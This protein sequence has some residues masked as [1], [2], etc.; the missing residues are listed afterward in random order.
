METC[1]EIRSPTL[2]IEWGTTPGKRLSTLYQKMLSQKIQSKAVIP[3]A[4]CSKIFKDLVGTHT[5]IQVASLLMAY[6]SYKP[7]IYPFDK[8]LVETPPKQM[9]PIGLFRKNYN[10]YIGYLIYDKKIEFDDVDTLKDVVYN[11]IER[12][13]Y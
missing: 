2:P 3:W 11:F 9:Y 6:M 1:Q 5:E 4:M 8:W 7:T 13:T 10:V 12:L